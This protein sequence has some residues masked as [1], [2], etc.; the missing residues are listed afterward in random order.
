MKLCLLLTTLVVGS[1]GTGE[2]NWDHKEALRGN[3]RRV[4][5]HQDLEGSRPLLRRV[6][7]DISSSYKSLLQLFFK[8]DT[9]TQPLSSASH[10]ES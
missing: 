3:T 10:S 5:L 4:S 8:R 1:Y 7:I 2:R 6:R 9:T